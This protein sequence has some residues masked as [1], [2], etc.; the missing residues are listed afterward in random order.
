MHMSVQ[1]ME[2]M[3]YELFRKFVSSL[4]ESFSLNV[5]E[6]LF[7]FFLLLVMNSNRVLMCEAI[8][9]CAIFIRIEREIKLGFIPATHSLSSVLYFARKE[10]FPQGRI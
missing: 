2:I 6:K 4:F 7:Q 3:L 10:K 9:Y 1:S 5:D 8:K